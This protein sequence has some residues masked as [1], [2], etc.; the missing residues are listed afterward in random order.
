MVAIALHHI[1]Y[2]GI[3]I[4]RIH[5]RI[6]KIAARFL[7]EEEKTYLG[8]SP[9]LEQLTIVWAAK[10]VMFKVYEHGGVT[11]NKELIVKPFD[12]QSE[13]ILNGLILKDSRI[14]PLPMKYTLV[15]GYILVE[16]AYVN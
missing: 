3:D 13:G 10:E 1:Q 14:I 12:I 6:R 5:P 2:P 8:S 15:K 16:T 4:E 9:T 7:S 11:F